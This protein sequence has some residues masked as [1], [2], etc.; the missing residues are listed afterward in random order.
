MCTFTCSKFTSAKQ[1]APDLKSN[2]RELFCTDNNV[3]RLLQ[4]E[5]CHAM[6]CRK[7]YVNGAKTALNL[8]TSMQLRLAEVTDSDFRLMFSTQ[9]Q[10]QGMS[11]GL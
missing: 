10:T 4:A 7:H 3:H 5:S 8:L 6:K 2:N 1:A 11:H 9:G